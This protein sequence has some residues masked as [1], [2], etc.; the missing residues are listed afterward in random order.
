MILIFLARLVDESVMA[1]STAL[2]SRCQSVVQS[3][4]VLSTVRDVVDVCDRFTRS[5]RRR[6]LAAYPYPA[7][8]LALRELTCST[9]AYIAP[10]YIS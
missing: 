6:A 4:V 1:L 7:S 3:S 9:P 10:A 5:R 2:T 8:L